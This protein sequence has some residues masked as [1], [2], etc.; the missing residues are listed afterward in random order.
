[1]G[2]IWVIADLHLGHEK[3][4]QYRGFSNA[5]EQDRLIE[6]RWNQVVNKRDTVWILGDVS[7]ER[8]RDYQKLGRLNGFKKVV[9]GNHDLPKGSHNQE[10]LKWVN[11]IAG[12]VTDRGGRWILTHVPVHPTELD[13]WGVN[14]HGHLHEESIGEPGWICVS[15]EQVDYTPVRLDSLLKD[16]TEL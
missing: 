14:I 5:D 4:A 11:S 9:L 10:M 12:A 13:R 16:I 3:M 6:E 7:M 15:C 8:K 2:T 1:M